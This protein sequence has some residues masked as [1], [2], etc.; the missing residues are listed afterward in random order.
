MTIHIGKRFLVAL[1]GVL[2][3]VAA[4]AV[5]YKLGADSKNDDV[6]A[7]KAAV[8]TAEDTAYD[9]GFA[10]GRQKGDQEGR[11]AIVAQ[12]NS[13]EQAEADVIKYLGYS[14]ADWK[15]EHWYIVAVTTRGGFDKNDP[16]YVSV[17]DRKPMAP[18]LE[19][20]LCGSDNS[21]LCYREG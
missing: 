10:Q 12:D 17:Y 15:K 16:K 20:S 6:K 14:S 1:V 8:K 7:A 3:V 9:R 13:Q 4:G 18:G 21:E 11:T 2:L 5:G 19:Y